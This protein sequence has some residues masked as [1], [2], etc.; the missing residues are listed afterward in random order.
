MSPVPQR[1]SMSA[2]DWLL[3]VGLSLLW[4]GSF[5]FAKIAV[6]ELPPLTV[7]LGRVAIAAAILLTL[8]RATA[9]ALPATLAAWR[10][11]ALMGLL[12]NALPFTLL[13]WGQTHIPSGLAAILN[14][15]TP[16]FTVLVAHVATA[17]E[18]LTAARL[19]GLTAGLAGVVMMIGPDVL[20]DF[21]A[22]V[23]A[24]LACLLAAISYA[25]AGVYGRR[26][27]GEPALRVAAGQLTASSVILVLPVALIDRPWML[28]AP[29]GKAIM[30]LVA[31]AAL[32]TALGYL[33]F[34]RI[35]ARAGATNVSLVTFLIPVSAILLGTLVLGEHLATRHF[36]GMAAIALGLAAID[37]R[38]VKLLAR[39]APFKGLRL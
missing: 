35:L 37:G 26:F 18:K 6:L 34:F 10:P 39:P 19:A 15:T 28:S 8:A 36:A 27:R 7:A 29:S 32:S 22:N 11:Y 31:L 33:I 16:L 14:A 20:R 13:F 30:A 3:L 4:G 2:A 25:F 24:Q 23:L 5:F 9:V 17:D 12:N 1:P 38:V 21:G